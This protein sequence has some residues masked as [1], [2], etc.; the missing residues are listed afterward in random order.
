MS[1]DLT[2]IAVSSDGLIVMPQESLE[3]NEDEGE[4]GKPPLEMILI[5]SPFFV[6]ECEVEQRSKL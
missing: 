3:Y 1:D 2:A 6:F 5:G 4:D